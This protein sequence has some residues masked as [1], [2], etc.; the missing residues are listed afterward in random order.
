A[1]PPVLTPEAQIMSK[2]LFPSR[3][4][5]MKSNRDKTEYDLPAA[6][7][8]I[9][10]TSLDCLFQKAGFESRMLATVEGDV[11]HWQCSGP[12]VPETHELNPRYRFVI[13]KDVKGERLVPHNETLRRLLDAAV[14]AQL[15]NASSETNTLGVCWFCNERKYHLP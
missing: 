7:G 6:P 8:L 14:P 13:G 3:K 12:C 11:V 15:V 10:T 1:L 5:I 4:K 2:Q 9:Y